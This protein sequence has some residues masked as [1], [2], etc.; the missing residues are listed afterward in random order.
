MLK[1]DRT[2][3]RYSESFKLKVLT[4]IE[5]GK[6]NKNEVQQIYGTGGNPHGSLFF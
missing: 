4:E 1:C 5:R 2:V 3:K 6:Y